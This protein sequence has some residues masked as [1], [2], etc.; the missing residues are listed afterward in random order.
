MRC[1]DADTGEELWKIMFHG[2]S[3]PSGN[4]G[5]NYAIADGYLVGLNG[6]DN[7]RYT[8]SARDPAPSQ[9][10]HQ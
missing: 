1:I 7:Q 6:Y 2:V 4:A 3:M 8:A 10:M 9:S 5:N